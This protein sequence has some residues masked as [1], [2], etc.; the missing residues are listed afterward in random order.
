MTVYPLI[1]IVGSIVNVKQTYVVINNYWHETES[2]LT[3]LTLRFKTLFVLDCCYPGKCKDL[4][5]FL[6]RTVFDIKIVGEKV[7]IKVKTLEKQ[8]ENILNKFSV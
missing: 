2:F 8:I 7:C 4:W 5:M 3:A 6:Q 1:F